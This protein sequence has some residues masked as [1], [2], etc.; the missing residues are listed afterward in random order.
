MK[1]KL[2]GAGGKKEMLFVSEKRI[3]NKD[4]IGLVDHAPEK[5]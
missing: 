5:T 4:K 3:N 2:W 1:L